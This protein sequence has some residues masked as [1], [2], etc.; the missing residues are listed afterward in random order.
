M[1]CQPMWRSKVDNFLAAIFPRRCILCDESAASNWCS[2]CLQDL[3]WISR[4]CPRCGDVLPAGSPDDVCGRCLISMPAVDR[5]ISALVYEYPVNRLIAMSKYHGRTDITHALGELLVVR[6]RRDLEAGVLNVPDTILP[7]PLH[8]RRLARRGFNQSAVISEPVAEFLQVVVRPKMCRRIRD[9]AEQTRMGAK[10]RSKNMRDAF[11]ASGSVR[12][13]SIAVV[14][15]VMTTGST[16]ESI[17]RA[18]KC[19]GAGQVQLWTVAR[20]VNANL[21]R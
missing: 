18:L 6:L 21:G 17:A 13:R 3:P 5:V 1:P 4:A 20:T 19:A 7:V 10:E 8:R 9:T 11:H 16:G 15:D 12:G 14:D 2:A